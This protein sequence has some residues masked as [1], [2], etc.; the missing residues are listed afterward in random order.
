MRPFQ[1]VIVT[2]V[3]LAA[4][5]IWPETTV[6]RYCPLITGREHTDAHFLN[7]DELERWFRG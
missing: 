3:S 7:L 6:K 4:D 1:R 2:G 5:A